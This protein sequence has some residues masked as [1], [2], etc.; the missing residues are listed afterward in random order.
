MDTDLH[1]RH[2]LLELI[3]VGC[4]K[5]RPP[6]VRLR[7]SFRNVNVW[8]GGPLHGRLYESRL[9]RRRKLVG[10]GRSDP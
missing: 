8:G 5:T 9:E 3:V 7:N 1:H 6:A 10:K 4:A 2:A